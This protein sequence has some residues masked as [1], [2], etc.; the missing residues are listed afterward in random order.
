MLIDF[1]SEEAI[2]ALR[3]WWVLCETEPTARTIDNMRRDGLIDCRWD[4]GEGT[5]MFRLSAAGM[6]AKR[7]MEAKD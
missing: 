5:I 3:D 6:E 1:N 4:A 7:R 2:T